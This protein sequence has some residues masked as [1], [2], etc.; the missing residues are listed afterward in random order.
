MTNDTNGLQ[1]S[2][3]FVTALSRQTESAPPPPAPSSSSSSTS[4]EDSEAPQ[5]SAFVGDGLVMD[6]NETF[7]PLTGD[8]NPGDDVPVRGFLV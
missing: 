1:L 5:G 7:L 8:I 4:A 6:G 2:W 3:H